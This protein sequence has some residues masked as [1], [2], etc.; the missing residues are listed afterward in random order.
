MLYVQRVIF[1]PLFGT[2]QFLLIIK[3]QPPNVRRKEE[4]G[5]G[6]E[7]QEGVVRR[8]RAVGEAE[9]ESPSA[10][11]GK[12]GADVQPQPGGENCARGSGSGL[13]TAQQVR[14][15]GPGR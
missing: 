8:R 9:V 7:E 12:T 5:E 6:S 11:E 15:P 1:H 14:A 2:D 13:R 3:M 10:G 4:W